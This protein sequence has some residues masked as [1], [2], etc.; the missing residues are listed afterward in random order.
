MSFFSMDNIFFR[1]VNKLLDLMWLNILTLIYCVPVITAG[2]SITSMYYVLLRMVN[3]EDGYITKN[4]F[5][6][7][8]QNFKQSTKVWLVCLLVMGFYFVDINILRQGVMTGYGVFEKAGKVTAYIVLF[9]LAMFMNYVFP[10]FARYDKD[11]KGTIKN[12]FLLATAYF[13][14]T[15]CMVVMWLFPVALMMVSNW[16]IL[17]GL[18]FGLTI[19]GFCCSQLLSS[20]FRRVENTTQEV[21]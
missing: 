17:F 11:V 21:G 13:P 6:A 15:I 18:F 20:L 2:T 19:P 8:K 16:F 12:A 5:S 1:T 14:R 9:I 4:F 10:L 7:F 3:H